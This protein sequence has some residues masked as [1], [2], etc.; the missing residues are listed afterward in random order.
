MPNDTGHLAVN[1]FKYLRAYDLDISPG[2]ISQIVPC[3]PRFQCLSSAFLGDKQPGMRTY[4]LSHSG[5]RPSTS[6][7]KGFAHIKNSRHH[8][9][10]SNTS[11]KM[12]LKQTLS[13]RSNIINPRQEDQMRRC[14][15]VVAALHQRAIEHLVCG[16]DLQAVR[17]WKEAL[18]CINTAPRSG[19]DSRRT[20]KAAMAEDSCVTGD[21][22]LPEL[23]HLNS[24][25]FQ[26]MA[27][28]RP[29]TRSEKVLPCKIFALSPQAFMELT[30][31]PQS[32]NDRLAALVLYH[33]ALS[34]HRAG[35]LSGF[36]H[37]LNQSLEFYE[38]ANS[39]LV[40]VDAPSTAD[41]EILSINVSDNIVTLYGLS[42]TAPPA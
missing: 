14:N 13:Q 8:I 35:I 28:P 16:E 33:I 34:F 39:I 20:G 41:R 24:S 30:S 29:D 19:C 12:D 9:H 11:I 22:S 25:F 18:R 40:H 3:P 27:L 31:P 17:I 1:Y 2:V 38:M 4:A 36:Q 15:Q 5:S 21:S 37:L 6:H 10:S 23:S 26:E 42:G 32:L 7:K